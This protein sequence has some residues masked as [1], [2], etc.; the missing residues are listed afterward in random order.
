MCGGPASPQ[1][2]VGPAP[3]RNEQ[4]VHSPRS[5]ARNLLLHLEGCFLSDGIKV[6]QWPL[7]GVAYT[8]TVANEPVTW[9]CFSTAAIWLIMS[10]RVQLRVRQLAAQKKVATR[11][12]DRP[13][14]VGASGD[15]E[16]ILR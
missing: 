4:Y 14:G 1:L 8:R 16:V 9:D 3:C 12:S 6:M 2:L 11:L 15:S 5:K 13:V 7:D 10:S